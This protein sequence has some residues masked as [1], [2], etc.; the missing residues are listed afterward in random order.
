MNERQPPRRVLRLVREHPWAMLPSAH[1]AML[2]ILS[3]RMA[4]VRRSPE[5]VQAAVEAARRPTSVVAAPGSIAILPLHGV[6]SQ[7][8]DMF[9]DVSG[10]TSTENYGAAFRQVMADPNITGV[11]LD[12]DSPGGSVYGVEELANLIYGARGE[13]PIIAVANSMCASAAYWVA[14]QADE[15]WVTPSGEIGSIGVICMHTDLS[16]R[17]E[18]EGVA[19][20]YITYPADGYK[21]EGNPYEPLDEETIAYMQ[22]TCAE[23][24]AAFE[25]AVAR[26]RGV[27]VG[28]VQKDFGRG[29]MLSASKA[30][31]AGMADRE[32]TLQ[33]AIDKLAKRKV[34]KGG[35]RAEEEPASILAEEAPL[36]VAAEAAELAQPLVADEDRALNIARLQLA[37]ARRTV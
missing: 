2:E 35:T 34:S 10:G 12:V 25:S 27:K 37:G 7:R 32:G 20:T 8:M 21:D 9:A 36:E 14:S 15:L 16:K 26:G 4:G 29:R 13:K 11:I 33:D 5:D 22:A 31:A 28:K 19:V 18:M 24:G 3:F 6:L 1:E 17:A 30:V 23:Y